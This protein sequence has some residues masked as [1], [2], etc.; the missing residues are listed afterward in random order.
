MDQ[1][2][3]QLRRKPG[4]QC[5]RSKPPSRAAGWAYEIDL[6]SRDSA[7]IGGT[8]A[9]NAGGLQVLRY[10]S[11]RAQRR[12]RGG[13][14]TVLILH[15]GRA[16]EG[17]HRLRPGGLLCGSEGTLGVVTAA[18]LR[19]VASTMSGQWLLGFDSIASVV[20]AG[21]LLR[22]GLPDLQS[23]ELFLGRP[24]TRLPHRR[25]RPSVRRR[26]SGAPPGRG[27][28]PASP[29]PGIG[30]G[31]RI[32]S[33]DRGERRGHGPDSAGSV[34]RYREGHTEAINALGAPHNSMSHFP[35]PCL[36]R[37]S[38]VC[39]QSSVPQ[40]HVPRRGSSVTRRM[41]VDVDM[42]VLVRTTWRSTI[43]CRPRGRTWGEHQRGA[44][45]RTAKRP[46][47]HSIE[48]RRRLRPFEAS[49]GADPRG[50]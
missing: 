7:T 23:L 32:G 22:R 45:H 26:P 30:R 16:D 11:T 1:I 21:F 10:G 48:V 29:V 4:R 50:S 46:W 37:S 20:D 31:A 49:G 33:V 34:W 8:I 25:R 47:L 18:R 41:D 6:G 40:T 36:L 44:R 28:G 43:A 15:L 14:R 35:L 13:A 12:D 24:R 39:R 19:L 42:T 2:G 3:G 17:Q 5:P 9:P 38:S 27:G